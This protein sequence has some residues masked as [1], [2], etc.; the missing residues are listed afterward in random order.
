MSSPYTY[1]HLKIFIPVGPLGLREET[2][3]QP[4]CSGSYIKQ[5]VTRVINVMGNLGVKLLCQALQSPSATTCGRVVWPSIAIVSKR[6]TAVQKEKDIF[7]FKSIWHLS[8]LC[9]TFLP[10]LLELI[11]S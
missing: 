1:N 5:S 11:H 6:L 2:L 9:V 3:P 8:Q 10:S 4:L 7:F